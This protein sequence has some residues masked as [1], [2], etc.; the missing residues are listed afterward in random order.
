[1]LREAVRPLTRRSST[2]QARILEFRL[3]IHSARAIRPWARFPKFPPASEEC[4]AYRG[5]ELFKVILPIEE[6]IDIGC[7]T[8]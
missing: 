7:R 4:I 3:L 8:D 5:R 2:R 1:M 6:K